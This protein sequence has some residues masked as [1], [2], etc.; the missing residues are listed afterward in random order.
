MNLRTIIDRVS[1]SERAILRFLPEPKRGSTSILREQQCMGTPPRRSLTPGCSHH[2]FF[3]AAAVVALA[4]AF[5]VPPAHAK[6]ADASDWIETWTASPQPIWDAEFFAPINVPRALRNQTVRQI[7]AIS[8][9]GNR[10]R[11]ELSNEY[12]S[13]PLVIGAAHVALAASGSAIVAGSDR[14]LSFDGQPSVTIPPGAPVISDPVDLTV[15]PLSNVA[16]SLFLPDQTPLTTFHWEGVQTAYISPEGNFAG[17]TDMKADSTIKARVFLS[18]IMVDAPP[19]A[20]ALVTFGDSITDGATSTPDANH[21]WPDV[22]ARRLA[23]AGGAPIAVLNQGISGARVLSDRMG[24]NAL[25]RF[26]RDVLSRPHADTVILMMGIND[27]GW[28]D[29]ILAPHEKAPSAD[30]IIDGYKQLIARAHLHGMRI[31]GATLTPFEDT[32]KGTPLEGYYNPEKEQKRQAVNDW[33]RTS[34]EF[35]GVIDFDAVAQDPNHPSHILAKFDS[36]DHLHPQDDGYKAM[37]DSIDLK[38]LTTKP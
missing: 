20:R 12:G 11:I 36:G 13:K 15:A 35:D 32:F 3:P 14:A 10:V 6:R 26:D 19:N 17:D 2:S 8:I 1:Y 22:L 4:A 16:V 5:I 38:M 33:I 7:A 18:G 24:V 31:I 30:A 29:S 28:P 25:A 9:G 21:R 27:I 23:E 34:G 37:A